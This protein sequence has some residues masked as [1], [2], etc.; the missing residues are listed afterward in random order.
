MKIAIIDSGFF[1]PLAE[2]LSK[3]AKVYYFSNWESGY[4]KFKDYCIGQGIEGV[5]KIDTI[6]ELLQKIDE[7]DL[8]I[9]PDCYY[10]SLA[11]WLRNEG[12]LV[13]GMGGTTWMEQD[14]YRLKEWMEKEKMPLP[15]WGIS[16][17]ITELKENIQEDR[18]IKISRFRGDMETMKHYDHKTNEQFYDELSVK[19]GG[20]KE[21]M[22]FIDEEKVDGIEWGADMWT[23]DGEFPKYGLHGVEIK[24][25]CYVGKVQLTALFPKSLTYTNEK[26]SKVF[27]DEKARGFF[28][29]EVRI[30]K[31]MNPFLIDPTM[32]CGNPPYQLYLT[33]IDNLLEVMYE[34]AKG[35]LIE[36]KFN[37]KYG[38]IAIIESEFAENNWLPIDIPENIKDWVMI[39][40][41]CVVDG[42]AYSLPIYGLSEVGAVVGVGNTLDEAIENCKKHAK[43]IKGYKLNIETLS[44]DEAKK[45][46]EKAKNFGINF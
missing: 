35:N 24:D 36:P 20:G 28:S 12:C 39:M 34:G 9:F 19:L 17:G 11:K 31:N 45:T 43:E 46:I 15:D 29:T 27:K 41:K 3:D 8:F 25:Q 30:D 23:V 44:F 18:F 33:M 14:R 6:G 21:L 37:A 10:G 5:E 13:W 26:L 1:L 42:I 2:R 32:R 22:E 7:I 4:P 40:N 16:T 38:A